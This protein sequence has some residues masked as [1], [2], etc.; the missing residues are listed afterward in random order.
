MSRCK[1]DNNGYHKLDSKG[2]AYTWDSTVNS[3]PA[4]GIIS[5][6]IV[7]IDSGYP[8]N[9]IEKTLGYKATI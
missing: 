2:T 1:L 6:V 4:V 9:T 8:N 3:L 7:E 5:R